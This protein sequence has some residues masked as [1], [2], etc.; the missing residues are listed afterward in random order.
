VF[1]LDLDLKLVFTAFFEALLFLGGAHQSSKEVKSRLAIW[2]AVSL[3]RPVRPIRGIRLG[4]SGFY[5]SLRRYLLRWGLRERFPRG[6]YYSPLPGLRDVDLRAGALFNPQVDIAGVRLEPE[7]QV[8]LLKAMASH[9]ADF[10]W[11]PEPQAGRRF[12]VE[13]GFFVEGDALVLFAVL[14]HFK[15]GRLIE[16]GS[17]FTSALMLDANER[18]LNRSISFTFIEPFPAR[19]LSLVG[20]ELQEKVEIQ[21]CSVQEVSLNQFE[22]LDENDVL[23][24]DSSHVAKIGSDVNF[25]MFE[26]LPRLKPGVIIHLHDIFWPFEY[27][28]SWI[29]EGRAWNEAYLIRAFLQFNDAFEILLFNSYLGQRHGDL[30]REIMPR[31][32]RTT[33]ASLWLRKTR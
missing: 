17:G 33:G 5:L 28:Q 2:C 26:V 24:I 21:P 30:V 14:R 23:F 15:T 3:H 22:K 20:K 9:A 19:L 27:P 16:V 29:N 12:Y 6:H 11:P 8:A 4:L 13:N 25:L 7:K 31:F 10:D 32:M 1:S 18:F